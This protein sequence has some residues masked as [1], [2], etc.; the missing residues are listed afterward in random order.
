MDAKGRVTE[1]DETFR[2]ILQGEIMKKANLRN[3]CLLT[4]I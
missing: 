4:D 3:R 1:V 2:K